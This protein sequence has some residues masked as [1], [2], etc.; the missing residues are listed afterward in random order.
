M[1]GEGGN[2]GWSRPD[3]SWPD[4]SLLAVLSEPA[5]EE[6]LSLGAELTLGSGEVLLTEGAFDRHLYVIL[7]GF[8]K[9]TATAENGQESLLAV[10]VGG[11]CVGEMAALD[12][13]PRS[14]GVVACGPLRARVISPGA[15]HGL[16]MR[17]PEVAMALTRIVADRL[18]WANRRR[19]EFR[20]YSVKIRL[21]RLLLELAV[22]YGRQERGG[23]R[24]IGFQLTQ[25]ELA[26]LTGAAETTVHK[27]L[28][29]LR[30][31]GLLGTGYRTTTLHD[32]SRLA[33][34]A[35]LAEPDESAG[36][37]ER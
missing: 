36:W 17:R 37:R 5:R 31:D 4:R 20:G 12:G 1:R 21:A 15:L 7:S 14:A 33:R 6:L 32:L 24:V 29:Q 11:D 16:M 19:L 26:A 18:R 2:Q 27:G 30:D 28:R 25:P 34:V 35:E 23:G 22:A 8:A 3:R 10:R 13:A 9:V